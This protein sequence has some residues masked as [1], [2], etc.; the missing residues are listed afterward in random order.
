MKNP[1]IYIA[2]VLLLVSSIL[3]AR[4][5]KIASIAKSFIGTRETS[6]NLGFASS[7]FEKEMKNAGWYSG[8]EWCAFFSRLVWLKALTGKKREIA[9][10]HLSGSSQRTYVNFENDKSGYF[11]TSKKPT[12]G[13]IVIWQSNKNKAKGHAGIV[14]NVSLNSF[15]VIEGNRGDAVTKITYKKSNPNLKTATLRGFIK[16]V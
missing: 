5:S 11:K 14:S 3:V 4:Y 8:A 2:I 9:K 6:P 1:Y 10:K 12:K 7:A 16:V 13:S 15:T